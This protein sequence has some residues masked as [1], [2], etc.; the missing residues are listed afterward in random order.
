MHTYVNIKTIISFV[1]HIYAYTKGFNDSWITTAEIGRSS[2]SYTVGEEISEEEWTY[3]L[4]F[5]NFLTHSIWIWASSN[6]YDGNPWVV[7]SLRVGIYMEDARDDRSDIAS[8]MCAYKCVI[9]I[10]IYV[11][12]C[13][14]S[15]S[16][17]ATV[18][19]FRLSL[20]YYYY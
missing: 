19:R 13:Y 20:L 4:F 7:E 18:H 16:S 17:L 14:R 11:Y 1:F 6:F 15:R 8:H 2:N 9:Y 12:I 3:L 5:R 10:F